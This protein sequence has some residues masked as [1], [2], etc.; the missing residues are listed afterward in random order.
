ME[1][2]LESLKCEVIELESL[3][4]EV[5]FIWL[6]VL[7]LKCEVIVIVW[8][9]ALSLVRGCIVGERSCVLPS[10]ICPNP[11]WRFPVWEVLCGRYSGNPF[12]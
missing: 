11:Q 8:L 2:V 12:V 9:C 4:C 1:V 5:I 6:S 10:C 7:S 3:K